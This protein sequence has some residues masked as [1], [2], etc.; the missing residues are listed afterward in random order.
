MS[1][2]TLTLPFPPGVTM[3]NLVTNMKNV[4]VAAG[5]VLHD[6][7]VLETTEDDPAW[8]VVKKDFSGGTYEDETVYL[9]LSGTCN[10]TNA[11]MGTQVY[12]SWD[13]IYHTGGNTV[14]YLS[15]S[16]AV[17]LIRNLPGTFVIGAGDKFFFIAGKNSSNEW[18]PD[19]H[20][21]FGFDR[22]AC[23]TT[24]YS[25]T[26]YKTIR[27]AYITNADGDRI[28]MLLAGGSSA[29]T[30]N[31]SV[32]SKGNSLDQN[33]LYPF[34]VVMSGVPH[35]TYASTYVDYHFGFPPDLRVTDMYGKDFINLKTGKGIMFPSDTAPEW[36]LVPDAVSCLCVRWCAANVTPV[37]EE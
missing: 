8:C 21:I 32:S 22:F 4:A 19:Y 10:G 5:W 20:L 24:D 14:S 25:T 3:G 37:T 1:V 33:I 12:D 26:T 31:L 29:V 27:M 23:D 17:D 18:L 7:G 15:G 28:R 30:A 16:Y 6:A 2:A 36:L 34:P 35:P 13:E 9:K 11:Q